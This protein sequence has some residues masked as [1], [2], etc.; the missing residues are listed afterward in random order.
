MTIT[1]KH[2]CGHS[3]T[4][5]FGGKLSERAKKIEAAERREC[6]KCAGK[7]IQKQQVF[8]F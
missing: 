6:S 7:E 8:K 5:Y 4:Q 3:S 2:K 1:I